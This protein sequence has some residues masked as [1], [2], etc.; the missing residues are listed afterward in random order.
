MLWDLLGARPWL[1][2]YLGKHCAQARL[3]H[4]PADVLLSVAAMAYAGSFPEGGRQRL[5]EEWQRLFAEHGIVLTPDTSLQATMTTSA[6]V[7]IT[8][9]IDCYMQVCRAA[10]CPC[11]CMLYSCI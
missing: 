1:S 5:R 9:P 7:H 8:I 4:L 3:E 11:L 10:A 6:Q 2:P